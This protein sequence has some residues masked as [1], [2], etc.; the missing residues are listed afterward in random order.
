[1][2]KNSIKN[3]GKMKKQAI[4]NALKSYYLETHKRLIEDIKSFEFNIPEF[5]CE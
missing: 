3:S 4:K 2:Q 1:M 5:D